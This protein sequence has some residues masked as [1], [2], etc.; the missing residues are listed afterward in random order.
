M[1]RWAAALLGVLLVAGCGNSKG[2]P[3]VAPE[4][5]GGRTSHSYQSGG[6][7]GSTGASQGGV[8]QAGSSQGGASLGEGGGASGTKPTLSEG[9]AGGASAGSGGL[10]SAQAGFSGSAPQWAALAPE[11]TILSPASAEELGDGVPVTTGM[12]EVV[13]RANKASDPNARDVN[14]STVSIVLV[15][16][17]AVEHTASAVT[18]SEKD[19]D[20][21]TTSFAIGA[22]LAPGRSEIRCTAEDSSSSPA[23]ASASAFV[24]IDFGPTIEID[25]PARDAIKSVKQVVRFKY[26]ITPEPLAV[27]DP[28]AEVSFAQLIVSGRTFELVEDPEEAGTYWAD[29]NFSDPSLFSEPPT[30]TTK[31]SVQAS[32]SRD[33]A[34]TREIGYSFTLDG[35]PPAITITAPPDGHVVGG[36]VKLRFNITDDVAGVDS[37]TITLKIGSR[38]FNYEPGWGIGPDYVFEFDSASPDFG[39]A[40][41]LPIMITAADRAGNNDGLGASTVL[42]LDSVAPV[43]SLDP[44]VV[45]EYREEEPNDKCSHVFDP[46]GE[47]QNDLSVTYTMARLRALVWER[48]NSVA[49]QRIF[50]HAGTD[51]AS[52]YIYLQ[53][54]P[55]V[56]LLVDSN[57]DG[58]CDALDTEVLDESRSFIKLAP[59]APV[60]KSNF[61]S[62]LAG[63]TVDTDPALGTLC[64]FGTDSAA[65][66]TL[67]SKTSDMSRVIGQKVWTESGSV[68]ATAIFGVGPIGGAACT[69]ADWELGALVPEDYEGW[70]CL[71]ARAKDNAGNVGVSRPLRLCLDR[72][73]SAHPDTPSCAVSQD[74][75]PTCTDGCTVGSTL[76]FPQDNRFIRL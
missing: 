15:D 34:V 56:P 48:T 29:V 11:V 71:A 64:E 2:R 51:E 35:R 68:M 61:Q 26:R 22:D 43:V 47:A 76:D 54:D 69:G 59:I 67:C 66:D 38:V 39:A 27:E 16:S 63:D 62:S 42:Y 3:E 45:R 20:E 37:S 14:P 40:V 73:D 1:T 72:L 5:Q 28:E 49:G 53:P 30:G 55:E 25:S 12:L 70:I 7:A 18:P 9:G 10:G 52:V 33:P 23:S 8:E 32:N 4:F 75:A 57:D 17:D 58:A 36:F 19:E 13:C 6:A 46:V 65:P 50:H 21:Y 74:D 41:Q 31:V 44:P 24:Y 60:G